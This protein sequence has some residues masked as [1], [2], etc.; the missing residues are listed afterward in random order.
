MERGGTGPGEGAH[1]H[2]AWNAVPEVAGP[3][4]G[5]G[6]PRR[7]R[8]SVPYARRVG[9]FLIWWVLL[10]SFWVWIDD[11]I[12]LAELLVGAAAA[13]IAALFAEIAQHQADSHIRVRF[14][15][16][17]PA[18]RVP[19][20]VVRDTVIVFGALWRQATRGEAP[21]SGFRKV[22]TRWGS[23]TAEGDTRR[24]L[25]IA[26]S[27]IAPNTFALGLDREQGVM[28]VHDLVPPSPSASSEAG[29]AQPGRGEGPGRGHSPEGWLI[30]R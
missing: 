21:R 30:E 12:D 2:R 28:I 8:R 1:L 25:L 4:A 15:W 5:A 19:G 9:S 29:T 27:S 17:V 24:T 23:E 26:A 16:L 3:L 11:S 20:Q 22:E 7:S 18:L 10:M 13:V 6:S 14:E